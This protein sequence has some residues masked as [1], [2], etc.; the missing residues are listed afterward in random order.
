MEL[1]QE[2]FNDDFMDHASNSPPNSSYISGLVGAPQLDPRVGLEY[3][4]EVPSI[5][6]QS[7]Q[8]QLLMN[9][10]ES[11]V[12]HDNSL[13]FAIGL[14]ISVTWIHN[15]VENSGHE[16]WGYLRDNRKELKPITSQSVMTGDNNSSQLGKSKTYALV[17]GT[18]SNSWSDTDAKSFLLGLYIF[19]KNFVQI[20]RFLENKGIG[21][22]LAFYY[23]KF[24][25]SDEY[26]RWSDCRKIKG[27]KSTIGQKLFTGRRLHELLSRLIPHVS[28][29][30]KDILL[31]VSKSYMEGRASLE[32]YISSLKSTVGLGVLVE[33][34]GIGKEKEDLTCLAVEPGKN[35]WVFSA[36]TCKAWSSLGPSDIMKF[37]TG[38]RLSKAKSKDLFWE[39]VWPRLLARGWHSEQPKNQGYVS[40][41]DYLVFL[42]PGV[43]EFSRTKLVKGDHYFDS[44]CDILSKVVAE[45]NLL[46]LEEAKVD[47]CNDEEPERGLNKDDQSDYHPQTYLKPRSST[48]NTDHIKF[49]VIDTS[50]VH[51]RK[52]SDLREFKSVPVNSVGNVEVNAAGTHK[53]AKYIKDMPENI[54]QKLTD[55]SMLCEGKLLPARELKYLPVEVENTSKME[56]NM[57]IYDK[58]NISNADSQNNAKKMEESLENQK[59]SVS[60]DNQLKSAIKQR[61]SPRVRPGYSK[62]PI[63]PFK[64]RRLTACAKAETSQIIGNSSGDLGSEK[65]TFSQE[66]VDD[67]VS[68]QKSG[69]SAEK[70]VEENNEESILNEVCQ[71]TSVSDDKVEKSESQSSVTFK[72]P[73][74]ALN[75]EDGERATVEEDGQCLK[76]NDQCLSSDAQAVVEQPPRTSGDVGSM[77][78][79]PNMNS[80]RQSTRNRSLSLR[81]L[82]SLANEFTLG[83]RR[84]KRKN[85]QTQR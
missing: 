85:I 24:Y 23:G 49:T 46:D 59:T 60:N 41:K 69:A 45:P 22:I 84:Q 78:N 76:A 38:F 25:K 12:G 82:E 50:L 7:E 56:A 83:E 21:E 63:L 68:C 77:E 11:E 6:K 8:L 72:I 2:N 64:K 36:P 66:N 81:A 13:S 32:E 34:V 61:F 37:L 16:G 52:S 44:V 27:R 48:Y 20:K 5:I 15:E 3:Q 73:Q 40:S 1:I 80:R 28:E 55:T 39:A 58:N 71:C 79:Q 17:P 57:L 4:V 70:S 53:G 18:L 31:Q 19:R 65:M 42:V 14:P 74:V 67:P 35:N 51:G 62:H 54:D 33:A 10:A 9:P 26:R 47:I 43:E 75:S 30:S 29:E